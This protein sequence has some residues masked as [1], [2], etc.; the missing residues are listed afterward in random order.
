MHSSP[1]KF[2]M[3]WQDLG[4]EDDAEPPAQID[5]RKSSLLSHRQHPPH[6]HRSIIETKK[7]ARIQRKSLKESGDYLGV[8]GINPKTGRLDIVT[9]TDSSDSTDSAEIRERIDTFRDALRQAKEA[10]RNTAEKKEREVR[11]LQIKKQRRDREAEQLRVVR[12]QR[13]SKQWSSAHEQHT[14]YRGNPPTSQ[15]SDL[16][17]DPSDHTLVDL[18]SPGKTPQKLR[19]QRLEQSKLASEDTV[20][21]TPTR[22]HRF[23]R[24]PAA[25][26][27]YENG[28]DFIDLPGK[29]GSPGRH[30]Q[31]G[32]DQKVHP[33]SP[34]K[35][36]A[37]RLEPG[38]G[39]HEQEEFEQPVGTSDDS[40]L[41][42]LALT[43]GPNRDIYRNRV[44]L[45]H[46]PSP[47]SGESPAPEGQTRQPPWDP[48]LSRPPPE[49]SPHNLKGCKHSNKTAGETWPP[50]MDIPTSDDST[51]QGS[52]HGS[53]R[54]R[55][56]FKEIKWPTANSPPVS[57]TA[58][59]RL[60][61][62]ASPSRM[63]WTPPTPGSWPKTR[64]D[65]LPLTMSPSYQAALTK[66]IK[67]KHGETSLNT[68]IHKLEGRGVFEESKKRRRRSSVWKPPFQMLR[69]SGTL[70]QKP[71][72]PKRG[73]S[74]DEKEARDLA[75]RQE[76]PEGPDPEPSASTHI[77]TT[78]GSDRPTFRRSWTGDL[79]KN[80]SPG[81]TPPS[82]ERPSARKYTSAFQHRRQSNN[83]LRLTSDGQIVPVDISSE[84][85]EGHT[86][87]QD[88]PP[89]PTSQPQ[90]QP[91]DQPQPSHMLS[92]MKRT[93]RA[94]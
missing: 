21:Y 35:G 57:P 7:N 60:H 48:D 11:R 4:I 71:K 94:K 29:G 74:L 70:S 18:S 52:R 47:N 83:L 20:V 73:L 13:T 1:A 42:T 82:H 62:P 66:S 9:S 14:E 72:K 65:L 8:Q 89:R 69:S 45:S 81:T 53:H 92:P 49:C 76:E 27:L 58:F 61:A 25:M 67:G 54:N 24:K 75:R 34:F 68:M 50:P 63:S 12:W 30:H 31:Q 55:S 46:Q 16:Q 90:D 28:I 79:R 2:E 78:T 88:A 84:A 64:L 3:S 6:V 26:E 39:P 86:E 40:F 91:Q 80:A 59:E 41:D 51:E 93:L 19:L 43:R 36:I 15:V 23:N 5:R 32:L 37:E 44:F 33:R 85:Q 77:T 22:R 10:Y 56:R 38:E 87:M 17:L